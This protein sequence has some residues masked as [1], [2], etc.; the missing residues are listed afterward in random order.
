MKI[1]MI[2]PTQVP[3]R[4]ANTIQVMKM[5]QAFVA[6]GHDVRLAAPQRVATS[7]SQP[8]S[9]IPDLSPGALASQDAYWEKIAR[10]YGLRYPFAIHWLPSRPSMRSYDFSLRAVRW[11][12]QWQA[13]LVYTRLPQAAA[14]ASLS[15]Q[16]TI[17]E[18]HDLPQGAAGPWL[19]RA[20]IQGRGARRLAVITQALANDLQQRYTIPSAFIVIAPDGVDLERYEGLPPPAEARR[21]LVEHH[22]H[23]LASLPVDR[24]TAGYSGHLYAGRGVSLLLDL[25]VRLP[26]INFIIAGGEP[27]DVADLREIACARGITNVILVGFVP[28]ADL[29]LYQAACDILLM[30]YQHRVAASSGGDIAP[31]LSPMKLFEYL[32]CGRPIVSSDLPVLQEILNPQNAILVA[33]D[34]LNAWEKALQDLKTAPGLGKRLGQQARRDAARYTWEMRA[35]RILDGL[36]A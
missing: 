22:N 9:D 29:P 6:L 1:A 24:F 30:P 2:A 14:F 4:R 27:K 18:T 34:D 23:D 10:H 8:S 7:S 28:N 13:D 17:L 16:A 25:A 11:A 15:G 35:R 3:A 26:E 20:F 21:R 12:R 36:E 5:A 33:A 31:Y 19:F 32:A